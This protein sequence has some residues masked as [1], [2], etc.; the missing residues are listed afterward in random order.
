M[1]QKFKNLKWI[2]NIFGINICENNNQEKPTDLY[3]VDIDY[4]FGTF[5]RPKFMDEIENTDNILYIT[6]DHSFEYFDCD[7]IIFIDHHLCE[8]LYDVFEYRSNSD[9]LV[10]NY[11]S[12]YALLKNIF[13]N[14][15]FNKINVLMHHDLDG[16]MSAIIIKKIIADVKNNTVDC[17]YEN[18]IVLAQVLGNAG[19]MSES[20]K[21]D[22]VKIFTKK[23]DIIIY[24]KKIKSFTSYF[25]RFMK[26]TRTM[27]DSLY[28]N[29]GYK[30]DAFIQSFEQNYKSI[31]IKDEDFY[32]AINLMTDF[33][34]QQKNNHDTT[35]DPAKY[36][37]LFDNKS[38]VKIF[39][40][41]C[42]IA[43]KNNCISIDANDVKYVLDFIY[44]FFINVDTVDTKS[45]LYFINSIVAD[46]TISRIV[47]IFS[48]TSHKYM[49]KCLTPPKTDSPIFEMNVIF[50]NDPNKEKYRL[51]FINTTA[52]S[53]RTVM[54]KYTY[55]LN[56]EVQKPSM[57]NKWN[58]KITDWQYS[59]PEVLKVNNIACFNSGI[60]KLSLHSTSDSAYNI[61]KYYGGGGH[62]NIDD[63]G[64]SMGSVGIDNINMLLNDIVIFDIF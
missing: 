26:A 58:Y 15:Y 8:E 53:S 50:T 62:S 25:G 6:V 11:K 56:K 52:D 22:L 37:K 36:N 43:I 4:R 51:L 60:N 7:N 14:F 45:I 49:T 38:V 46:N 21:D 24:N 35:K 23:D 63:S 55:F 16:V 33:Y 47:D 40:F 19:D 48:N 29:A 30:N 18:N 44:S 12:T 5:S 1:N 54:G 64:G 32:A 3:T 59:K 39:D 10:K 31:K 27:Y 42:D 34:E 28:N 20:A 57:P 9:L 2:N 61:A 13:D 17:N 41:M